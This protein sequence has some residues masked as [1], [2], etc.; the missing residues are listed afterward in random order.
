MKFGKLSNEQMED[1]LFRKIK[2]KRKETIIVPGIGAD[3][4]IADFGDNYLVISTDPITGTEKGIGRLCV[5]I[6]CNDIAAAGG[7]PIGILIT[8]LIPPSGL[9]NRLRNNMMKCCRPVMK[10]ALI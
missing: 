3:C 10:T 7:E 1:L 2:R 4:A 5:N 6:C 8:I 9:C